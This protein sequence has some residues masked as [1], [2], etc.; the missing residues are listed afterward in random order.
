MILIPLLLLA[1][2]GC[3][4]REVE[5]EGPYCAEIE[6]VRPLLERSTGLTFREPPR[7]E[8]RTTAQVRE[9][10]LAQLR[11]PRAIR[12][13]AGMEVA[14]KRFGLIPDTLQLRDFLVQLLEEQIIGYYDP[15]TKVLYVVAGANRDMANIT[16]THELVH[17]LQDQ[18][19][20]LREFQTMEGQNDRQTAAQAVFE[21][22]AVF[23][24]LTVMLGG[25]NVAVNLPGGWDRI[26]EQIREAQSTMPVFSSAPLI[27]QETL[28]FPYLTGA[29]FVRA[30]KTRRPGESPLDE[31]P[32]STEQ[33]MHPAKFFGERDHPTRIGLAVRGRI[34]YENTLGEFETRVL[35][36]EYTGDQND[37]VRG[38]AG[39]DGD[40]YATVRTPG[41]DALVWVSVWDTQYDAG[42]FRDLMQR[43]IERRLEVT[44]TGEATSRTF[45]ARGRTFQLSTVEVAARP[46]VLYVDAPAGV[47][48]ALVDLSA[49]RLDEITQ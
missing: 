25:G 11:E 46:L 16:V 3:R 14:Y 30:F 24:Q 5:C 21:G 15:Q 28:I 49:L 23:E 9:F 2:A 17:A 4:S 31:V 18:Y 8:E 13:M 20:N 44:G 10:V 27:L 22:Q 35:L 38:A 6:R 1:A 33:L 43:G 32:L 45:S 39:W 48:P 12:E 37:A 19:V 42:E 36:Y 41:G 26:R 29:E 34:A 40:R 7:I 47:S